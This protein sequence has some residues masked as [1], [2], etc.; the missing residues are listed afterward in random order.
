[1]KILIS[2]KNWLSDFWDSV[3]EARKKQA[4]YYTKYK[5]WK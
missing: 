3:I 1:M 5:M 2:I 4:E